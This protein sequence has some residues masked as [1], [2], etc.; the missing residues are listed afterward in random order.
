MEEKDKIEIL[1]NLSRKYAKYNWYYNEEDE[2]YHKIDTQIDNHII[3]LS[4]K[5]F[6]KGKSENIE[7][8]LIELKVRNKYGYTELICSNNYNC[9]VELLELYNNVY[10]TVSMIK[11]NF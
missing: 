4:C 3:T 8:K 2:Y 6:S 7:E 5:N 11:I 1:Y 10:K 9:S